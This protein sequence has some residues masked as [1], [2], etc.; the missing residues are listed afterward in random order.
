MDRMTS[1]LLR[2]KPAPSVIPWPRVNSPKFNRWTAS[3]TSF[4]FSSS[5]ERPSSKSAFLSF[6]TSKKAS[7]PGRQTVSA[8]GNSDP[9]NLSRVSNKAPK[10]GLKSSQVVRKSSRVE[11]GSLS[12]APKAAAEGRFGGSTTRNGGGLRSASVPPGIARL[13]DASP[14]DSPPS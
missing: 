11:G 7:E 12:A 3:S 1:G 4:V 9:E 14:G 5:S 10:S 8:S 2:S 6:A 13:V